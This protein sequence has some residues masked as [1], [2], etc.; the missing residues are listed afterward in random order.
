VFAG[1]G[2]LGA[3]EVHC[4]TFTPNQFVVDELSSVLSLDEH[5]RAGRF[6]FERDR[7]EYVVCR[8]LLRHLLALYGGGPAF[9]RRFEYTDR[10]KPFF[11]ANHHRPI[12]FSVAHSRGAGLIGLA[13]GVSVGVDIE[14]M[15]PDVHLS[16]LVSTCFAREE[17]AEFA[18]LPK[19]LQPRAFYAGWTRKEAL[20]KATGEGLSRPLQTFAVTIAPDSPPKL[21]RFDGDPTAEAKWKIA[22]LT[23]DR[24]FAAAVAVPNAQAIVRRRALSPQLLGLK[25]KQA[26]SATF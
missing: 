10:G 4:W 17:Q 18:S 22:D 23:C 25:Q 13:C 1:I 3:N 20:I 7:M 6:V 16:S 12:E 14:E 8:G 26:Q 11:P 5:E 24:A 9:S 15:R 21:I 2:E 19:W